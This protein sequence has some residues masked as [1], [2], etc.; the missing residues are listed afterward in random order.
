[1]SGRAAPAGGDGAGTAGAGAAQTSPD[2]ATGI[3]I[4]FAIAGWVLYAFLAPIAIFLTWWG[5]CEL[6]PCA[7]P[8]PL[9]QAAYAFDVVW[10]LLFPV[11]AYFAYRGRRGAW[12]A[13]LV[14]ALVLDLQLLAS[15][16]GSP[17][18][19]AFALTLPPAALLTFGA[20][21]GLAMQVPR[22]RDRPGAATAGELAGIGCLG[23][24]VGAIALQGLLVGVGG[25]L[26]G[27]AVLMAIALF[28]IGIAA[29]AN[30]N[31]RSG[32]RRRVRR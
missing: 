13:M 2:A 4:G 16:L 8:G 31:R 27:I 30:R 25:P 12:I 18:F 20:G 14:A 22:V 7:V 23:I 26:V 19:S 17:G 3:A 29:F 21:L 11:V 24:V 9:D 5:D 15:L 32:S 28:V 1:M 10:W 6:D